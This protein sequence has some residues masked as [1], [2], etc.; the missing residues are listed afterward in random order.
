MVKTWEESKTEAER[1]VRISLF[2]VRKD[3]SMD[4][5]STIGSGKERL[6]S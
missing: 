6:D 1:P 2:R 4:Q 5:D 3:R